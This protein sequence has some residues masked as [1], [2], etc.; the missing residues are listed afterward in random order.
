M[1]A[2]KTCRH[3]LVALPCLSAEVDR[4]SRAAD[5]TLRLDKSSTKANCSKLVAAH[6]QMSYPDATETLRLGMWIPMIGVGNNTVTVGTL[7]AGSLRRPA[8]K[9]AGDPRDE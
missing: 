9:T 4:P 2:P 5:R 1:L 3:H 6:W 8:P 7:C